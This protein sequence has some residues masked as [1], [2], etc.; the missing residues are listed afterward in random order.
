MSSG[1][2]KKSEIVSSSQITE[3]EEVVVTEALTLTDTG[4]NEWRVAPAGCVNGWGGV[5]RR[6]NAQCEN[7]KEQGLNLIMKKA[8][9]WTILSKLT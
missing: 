1:G 9:I 3:M 5:S 8:G 6:W 2:G 7:A 4:Q